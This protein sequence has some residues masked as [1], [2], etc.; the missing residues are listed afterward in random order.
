[1]TDLEF[2]ASMIAIL[3]WPAAIVAIAF[4]LRGVVDEYLTPPPAPGGLDPTWPKPRPP[5]PPPPMDDRIT[6]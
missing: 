1:M 6:R 4:I 3:A 5:P 2:I